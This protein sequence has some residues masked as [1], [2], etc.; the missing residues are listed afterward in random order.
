MTTRILLN[1]M[2]TTIAI[3]ALALVASVLAGASEAAEKSCRGTVALDGTKIT[4]GRCWIVHVASSQNNRR[5]GQADTL[6]ASR[7]ER[8]VAGQRHHAG[9]SCPQK[10]LHSITQLTRSVDGLARSS[11]PE[12]P[13]LATPAFSN[14]ACSTGRET[15]AGAY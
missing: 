1:T 8:V 12:R 9:W 5:R 7:F 2:I 4:V 11:C 13:R 10:T 6:A 14:A 15:Y 3:A